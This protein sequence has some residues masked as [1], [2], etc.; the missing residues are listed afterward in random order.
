MDKEWPWTE[1][2]HTYICFE[3]DM[4]RNAV[5]QAGSQTFHSSPVALGSL[6]HIYAPKK[7]FLPL[8]E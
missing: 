1:H 8:V 3:N 6:D 2:I 7:L 4:V 5:L